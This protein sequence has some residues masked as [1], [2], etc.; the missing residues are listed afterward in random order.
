MPN[1]HGT[2]S[3]YEGRLL[4]YHFTRFLM[5]GRTQGCCGRSSPY[6]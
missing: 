5:R 1:V 6:H 4:P 2:L 3:V